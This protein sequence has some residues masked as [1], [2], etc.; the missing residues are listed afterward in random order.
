[1]SDISNYIINAMTA[2]GFVRAIAADTTQLVQTAVLAHETFPVATAALGRALT[3]A[4]LLSSQLKNPSD[5]ITLQIKGKG[6]LGGIVAV[7]SYDACVKGYI[8]NPQVD[9]PLTAENKLDVGKA[10]GK[11]FL[12]VIKD[13]GL[14]EPYIG[15]IALVSGEIAEDLAFYFA[16][17][18]QIPT[19]VALGVLVG[20]D[21]DVIK[22][23]GYMIQLMPGA[24][25]E[26][27]SKLEKRVSEFPAISH[28]MN[29]GK[30]IE[31]IL[32][33]LFEGM[34]LIIKDTKPC[35]YKCNCSRERME[36]NLISLGATELI[37]L[38]ES[39]DEAELVCHFCNKKYIFDDTQINKLIDI[40]KNK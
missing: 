35:C 10:V 1:M 2:D 11:G 32:N 19:V 15:T 37:D 6:P 38:M 25:E 29:S 21:G 14:K 16:S 30:T 13:L 3:G 31:D 36:R 18:E 20:P 5:S 24:S 12:S 22:A 9:L 28:F 40:C 4:V 7:T 27:I 17:S 26:L 34:D 39:D 8:G 33:T 23:G